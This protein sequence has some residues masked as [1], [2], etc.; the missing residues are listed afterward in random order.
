MQKRLLKKVV[1]LDPDSDNA[2]R[3]NT[4]VGAPKGKFQTFQD[5]CITM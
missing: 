1:H 2:K 3:L 4:R 5:V